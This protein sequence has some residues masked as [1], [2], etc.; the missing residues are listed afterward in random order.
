MNRSIKSL[1]RATVAQSG[2]SADRF[3]DDI[4]NLVGSTEG[5]SSKRD[6]R[7]YLLRFI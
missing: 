1:E 5:I 7:Y 6:V 2:T 4:V 3:L